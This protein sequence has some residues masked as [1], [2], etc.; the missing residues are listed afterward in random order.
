MLTTVELIY[1]TVIL[2]VFQVIIFHP[3][4]LILIII[5]MDYAWH[6]QTLILLEI[7]FIHS[8]PFITFMEY[9]YIIILIIFQQFPV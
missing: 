3:V 5:I 9:I 8:I 6:I 2:I 1:I 4:A 7:K